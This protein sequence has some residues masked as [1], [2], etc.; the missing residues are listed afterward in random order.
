M[1]FRSADTAQHEFRSRLLDQVAHPVVAFDDEDRVT[2]WNEAAEELLGWKAD[3]VVGWP[4]PDILAD[5]GERARVAQAR[6]VLRQ[7][8]E[9]SGEVKAV[10]RDGRE[11]VLRISTAPAPTPEG[12]PGGRVVS[13]V[14][15]TDLRVN[16]ERLELAADAGRI[17]VFAWRLHTGE[18]WFSESCY[19]IYG[20]E[21]HLDEM[22]WGTWLDRVYPPDRERAAAELDRALDVGATYESEFRILYPEGILR[23]LSTR[24]RII[25]RGDGQPDRMVGVVTDITERKRAEEAVR[26]NEQLF[27]QIAETVEGIF[28][29]TSMETGQFEYVS[30]AYATIFG[31]PPEELYA[32]SDLWLDSVHPDDRTRLRD[33]RGLQVQGDYDL[34][35]RI[36]RPDGSV[37]W[38]WDRAFPT[39]SATGEVTRIVGVAEDITERKRLDERLR[40]AQKM[41]AVG[42]LSGGVAHDFNNRLTV[43]QNSSRLLLDELP[44]DSP[45]RDTVGDILREADRA[46]TSTRQLLAF[47]RRRVLD[48]RVLDAGELLGRLFPML[49]S[50]VPASIRLRVEVE[51]E[52]CLIRADRNEVEQVVLNLVINAADAIREDTDG[53]EP[54]EDGAQRPEARIT[55]RVRRRTLNAE[56]GDLPPGKYIQLEVADTGPGMPPEV[57]ERIFEPFFTTKPTHRGTGLG[58]ATVYGVAQ[59]SGGGVVVASAQGRGTTFQVL[60]PAAEGPEDQE[61]EAAEPPAAS[62]ESP[63]EAKSTTEVTAESIAG[64]SAETGAPPTDAPT[65]SGAPPKAPTSAP[66]PSGPTVLLVEDEVPVRKV[67]TRVLKRAGY[68]VLQAET[69]VQALELARLHGDLIDVVVSDVV[70]PEMDGSTLVD[71]LREL[72]PDL[73]VILMSGYSEKELGTEARRK[74]T[75]FLEKPFSPDQLAGALRTATS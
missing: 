1:A 32:D 10:R 28:W 47:S 41:D 4:L 36:V 48:E 3:E 31:R 44:E 54:T 66:E 38:I 5:E 27:R 17:G 65:E 39:A 60:F 45:L 46:A 70:M 35:Y 49:Q 7:G 63:S 18:Q 64:P 8:Q 61:T 11:V 30:P 2:F 59:Q 24:A 53:D 34:E 13:A 21:P 20:L 40:Q 69:G 33:V 6:K 22:S 55:V 50:L 43:I 52:G 9:W 42:R 73:A 19:E 67:A 75:V 62:V 71:R 15:V 72:R 56:P 14:D 26:E 68:R 23:W 16:Q 25:R 51:D 58:L 12:S 74:A 29:I 57:E 37:R